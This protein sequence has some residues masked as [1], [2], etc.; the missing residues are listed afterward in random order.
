MA[1]CRDAGIRVIMITGDYGLTAESVARRIGLLEPGPRPRI[2]NGADL[3]RMS[4]KRTAARRSP[5]G[6]CCL[7]ASLRS[8]R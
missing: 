3:E 5:I 4:G 2:V 6:R 7:P 8:T 1:E